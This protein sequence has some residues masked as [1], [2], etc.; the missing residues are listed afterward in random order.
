M[1]QC[2]PTQHNKK[3]RK[4]EVIKYASNFYFGGYPEEKFIATL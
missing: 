2:T 3:K 4:K 1:P